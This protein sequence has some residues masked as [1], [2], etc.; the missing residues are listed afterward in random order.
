[1][2]ARIRASPGSWKRTNDPA[3]AVIVVSDTVTRSTRLAAGVRDGATLA[4]AETVGVG[5]DAVGEQAI[6]IAT[7]SASAD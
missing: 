6:V 1:V 4:V 3:L 5:P 2:I 7:K